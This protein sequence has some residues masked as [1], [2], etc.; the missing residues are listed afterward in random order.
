MTTARKKKNLT[1]AQLGAL[2]GLSAQSI[3]DIEKGRTVGRVETWDK[4]SA[5]L[6]VKADK[7]RQIANQ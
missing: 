2:V 6:K 3:C 4:L 7:L 1:L 5:V